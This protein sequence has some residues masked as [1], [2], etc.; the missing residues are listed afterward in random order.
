MKGKLPARGA[1][2]ECLVINGFMILS[3]R[4]RSCDDATY[5]T[6]A[7]VAG[8]LGPRVIEQRVLADAAG[9]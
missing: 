2:V 9:A 6:D 7:R 3:R 1:L 5:E 4:S 8:K